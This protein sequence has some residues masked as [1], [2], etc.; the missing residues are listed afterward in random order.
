M[1]NVSIDYCNFETKL[2]T[3]AQMLEPSLTQ[4]L[5]LTR[6]T[7]FLLILLSAILILT[8]ISIINFNGIGNITILIA[9]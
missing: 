6:C 3:F 5:V 1:G 7:N 9:T 4:C 8:I 2:K